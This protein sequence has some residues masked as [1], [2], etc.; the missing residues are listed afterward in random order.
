MFAH[1][2]LDDLSHDYEESP[3]ICQESDL[4]LNTTSITSES[5][6]NERQL[7]AISIITTV[8]GTGSFSYSGDGGPATSATF[9]YPDG[10]AVD[11]SGNIY[12]A[13]TYNDAIRMVTK[14]TGIITTVASTSTSGY[15]GD[16]GLATSATLYSPRGVA[17]D[18][19]GN[20]YIADTAS[21]AIRMVTKST[22][23]ITT[24]AGT[25]QTGGYSGDGGPATSATFIDPSCVAV[26]LS[27]NIYI[28]D[29]GNSA[30]RMVTMSTGII[31]TV[32]GT[33]M[34]GYSGDGGPATLAK[35]Y[36]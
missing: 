5:S 21:S 26:D 34:A 6:E 4:I 29:T 8:A 13:D 17:V 20:I 3:P 10:V 14:S 27:G 36:L 2:F 16:G 28:A 35:L 25:P 19:S 30:I 1:L 24:V 23:I 12:I 11:I 33:G 7:S 32:A 22:G 15:S 9:Y 31:T 18:I